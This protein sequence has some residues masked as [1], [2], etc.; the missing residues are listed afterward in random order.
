MKKPDGLKGFRWIIYTSV[1][2]IFCSSLAAADSLCIK[3]RQKIRNGK[4][5]TKKIVIRE[6]GACP[7]RYIELLNIDDIANSTV[8]GDRIAD[9][10]ITGDKIADS[11]I[12]GAKIADGS[13]S[14]TNLA[15]NAKPA[16]GSFV[17]GT[18]FSSLSS[19]D[20]IVRSTTINAPSA[21]IVIANATAEMNFL[22]A[23]TLQCSLTTGDTIDPDH[24]ASRRGSGGQDIGMAITRGFEV[25]AGSTTINLVCS[26]DDD[27]EL[28]IYFSSLTALFAPMAS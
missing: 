13:V 2:V 16:R 24:L 3:K 26:E 11:T 12:N 15:S 6:E 27:A 9:S 14:A 10:T 23:G 20:L 28:D 1:L 4:V 18:R 8:T 5:S 17:G 21:G 25:P 7:K 19:L 22:F